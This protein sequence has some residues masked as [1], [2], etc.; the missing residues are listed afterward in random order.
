MSPEVAVLQ[1]M[2]STVPAG[3]FYMLKLPQQTTLPAA[4]V[5]LV[6]DVKDPHLRGG[7]KSGI[8]R[9]QV[10]VYRSEASGVDSYAEAA[11]L[12]DQIH[13]DD[14]GSGLSGFKGLIGG[15]PDGLMLTGVIFAGRRTNYEPD[16]LR[17][18]GIQEDYLAHYKSL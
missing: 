16:E 9:V 12:M 17:A 6:D 1:V 18:V 10:T 5:Q 4:V 7:S 11:A 14:A 15:S 2:Q 8:A 3:R 13:G